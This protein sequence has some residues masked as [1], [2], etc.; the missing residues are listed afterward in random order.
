VQASFG[1]GLKHGLCSV[2]DVDFSAFQ[3]D[4]IGNQPRFEDAE[5]TNPPFVNRESSFASMLLDADDEQSR[6]FPLLGTRRINASLSE[7][8][9]PPQFMGSTEASHRRVVAITNR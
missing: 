8:G 9:S 6:V 7:A 5:P 4:A 2:D 1:F 3:T